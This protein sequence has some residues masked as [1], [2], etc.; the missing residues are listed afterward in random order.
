MD[1]R[2]FNLGNPIGAPD[3]S[4]AEPRPSQLENRL[5]FSENW[6]DAPAF[7]GQEQAFPDSV[8]V[9]EEKYWTFIT[10][11]SADMDKYS[12]ISLSHAQGSGYKIIER[13]SPVW[14]ENKQAHVLVLCVQRRQFK[15]MLTSNTDPNDP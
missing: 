10:T 13:S 3:E 8:K 15:S 12:E 6:N 14:S 9:V 11:E 4:A 5:K 1:G 7:L 2:P